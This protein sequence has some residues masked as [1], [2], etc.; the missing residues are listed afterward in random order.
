MG[1][2]GGVRSLRVYACEDCGTPVARPAR[3]DKPKL[4]PL[5]GVARAVHNVRR[6]RE[7]A[8]HPRAKRAWFT[9][10]EQ[11]PRVN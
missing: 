11:G 5:C 3:T 6:M 1:D 10:E 8:R 4:C 9:G 2:T 7:L